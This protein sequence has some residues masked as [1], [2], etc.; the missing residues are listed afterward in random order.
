MY[1]IQPKTGFLQTLSTKAVASAGLGR[2]S[3]CRQD[4]VHHPASEDSRV[5]PRQLIT[6]EPK[7]ILSEY[8]C[9]CMY[10][11]SNTTLSYLNP[12][13]QVKSWPETYKLRAIILHTL[14]VQ[15]GLHGYI[16]EDHETFAATVPPCRLQS[17]CAL[18]TPPAMLICVLVPRFVLRLELLPNQFP[19]VESLDGRGIAPKNTSFRT[20]MPMMSHPKPLHINL[21]SIDQT[22]VQR[23]GFRVQG[24][25]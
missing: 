9:I 14:G 22:P 3:T 18:E 1:P 2:K 12:P 5:N 23:L 17:L 24:M 7:P 15:V 20:R 4:H 19:Q 25:E 8:R 21:S 10:I 6:S 16:S 11:A 13:K